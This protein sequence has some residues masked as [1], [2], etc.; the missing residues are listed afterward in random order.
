VGQTNLVSNG[1]FE[2]IDSCYGNASALGFDVF[3]WSGCTDWSCPTFASSDLWC[4]NPI[5]GIITPP[6][7]PGVGYQIPR[8]GENMAGILV[9]ELNAKNY[10]E[11]IQNKLTTQLIK[12]KYYKFSMYISNAGYDA[13]Y[14]Q[15]TSCMQVYFSE[16][17]LI[18]PS[19]YEPIPVIPQI[20]NK[21]S[22][23]Y[24]DTLNWTLFTGEFKALGNEKFITIG[25]FED[26]IN[27]SLS[28]EPTDTT[29]GDNYFFI[30]DVELTESPFSYFIP[31]VF[32]PNGDQTNDVF[33][34]NVNNI[35]DWE[36]LIYNRWGQKVY[37]LNNGINSWDGKTTAGKEVPNG[38]YYY[39]FT[40]SIEN[41]I[42][43]E[44]G[45]LELLR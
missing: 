19:S 40:A 5:T 34:P 28:N 1:S 35:E 8:T 25:C 7:I 43:S 37:T 36:C 24:I 10:R 31:N 20:I 29:G 30:D 13:I 26:S 42:I 17:A 3:Q 32:S 39:V 33:S 27:I 15:A 41:E 23:F 45:F 22:N 38:T 12:D 2:D 4:E 18:Q 6:F 44:K 21:T 9:F 14:G 11:Y 16:T